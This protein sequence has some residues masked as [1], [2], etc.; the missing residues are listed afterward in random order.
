MW[1]EASGGETAGSWAET[2]HARLAELDQDVV[3]SD[4]GPEL[5]FDDRVYKRGALTLHAVRST[6]GDVAFFDLLRSWVA[7]HSGR[8]V[9]GADFTDFASARTGV[10]LGPLFGSWLDA[11]ELPELPDLPP[12]S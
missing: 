2:H 4:P 12:A 8:N 5:M 9:T 1:S 10:D 11:P 3:L 7:E 6:V